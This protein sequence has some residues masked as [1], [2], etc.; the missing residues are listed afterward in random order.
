[1]VGDFIAQPVAGTGDDSDMVRPK[2]DLLFEFAKHGLLRRF[3]ALDATL[4]KL[5]RM[6]ADALAPKYLVTS[7]QQD[8]PNVGAIA[9]FVQH[10]DRPCP[11]ECKSLYPS[12]WQLNMFLMQNRSI[13]LGLGSKAT[14][15][16]SAY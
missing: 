8:D 11:L 7:V 12:T 15:L 1:M 13:L 2:S 6:F 10:A 16:K 3:T 5:P 4:R 9:V 14:R